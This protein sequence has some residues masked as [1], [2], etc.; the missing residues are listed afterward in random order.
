MN[1][2]N[3]WSGSEQEPNLAS[4]RPARKKFPLIDS[5]EAELKN[6][7]YGKMLAMFSLAIVEDAWGKLPA[8]ARIFEFREPIETGPSIVATEMH[9]L[10][11]A[12]YGMAVHYDMDF[13]AEEFGRMA[14]SIARQQIKKIDSSPL[15]KNLRGS[16]NRK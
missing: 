4:S 11:R 9:L 16:F 1:K 8:L 3:P 14:A 6:S 12:A 13:D 15:T 5:S 7:K 10:A 2:E